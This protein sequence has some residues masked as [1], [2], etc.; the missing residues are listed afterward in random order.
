[1]CPTKPVFALLALIAPLH[2][3]CG[4]D[5][6]P[7]AASASAAPTSSSTGAS[8]AAS[9]PKADEP[10][11][12]TVDE[13]GANLHGKRVVVSEA[14]GPKK[15]AAV[16]A[17]LPVKGRDL[18]L[19]VLKKSKSTDVVSVVRE[20]GG[21]G[22]K[23]VKIRSDA[24]NDLPQD[25]VVTP[26][27]QLGDKPAACSVVAMVTAKLETDV[28]SVSGG[29]A[30]MHKKGFA[31][32]DLSNTGETLQKELERCES[33]TAF[34]AV[35]PSLGWEIAHMIGGAILAND[36]KKKIG[37]LVLLDEAPVPGRPIKSL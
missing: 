33:N 19:V 34:F 13:Q 26:R 22:A 24:R 9:K 21:A 32:P 18:D 20:L 4:D 5:P 14:G 8:A 37:R 2:V 31:G 7:T 17:E 28:W 1:M 6:K 10:L 30:K 11:A 15:L 12:L 3:G 29:V 35:D 36:S 23:T 25:L 27:A 16:V